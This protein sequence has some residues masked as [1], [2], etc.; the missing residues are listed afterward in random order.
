M[1]TAAAEAR[2]AKD[3]KAE[4]RLKK[5]TLPQFKI[6]TSRHSPPLHLRSVSDALPF[7]MSPFFKTQLYTGRLYDCYNLLPSPN[8][9]SRRGQFNS[10]T[11]FMAGEC[12]NVARF[13]ARLAANAALA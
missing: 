4:N 3:L 12:K 7:A 11:A 1:R 10:C 6:Q 8:K 2:G 13:T 9:K 5:R